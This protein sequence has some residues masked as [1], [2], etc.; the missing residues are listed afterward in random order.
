MSEKDLAKAL[1]ELVAKDLSPSPDPRQL[2]LEIIRRDKMWIRLLAWLTVIFWLIGTAGL[3]LLVYSLHVYILSVR[4][5]GFSTVQS[6]YFLET[7]LFHHS[8]GVIAGAIVAL[9]LG[10]CCTVVLVFSSRRATLRQINLSLMAISEQ[11]KDMRKA[12]NSTE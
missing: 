10:A 5:Q 1:Q 6:S 7:G 4:I 12:A 3:L 11:L 2:I 8:A 9:L